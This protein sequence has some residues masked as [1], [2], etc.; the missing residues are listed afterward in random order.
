VIC[1]VDRNQ[2]CLDFLVELT[3]YPNGARNEFPILSNNSSIGSK[4]LSLAESFFQFSAGCTSLYG[5]AKKKHLLESLI[6][7]SG[8]PI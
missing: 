2:V 3:P 5:P 8:K 7:M 1:L 6:I 4:F